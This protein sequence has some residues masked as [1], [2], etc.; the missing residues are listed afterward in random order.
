MSIYTIIYSI[1]VLL[2]FIA[3]AISIFKDDFLTKEQEKKLK[4]WL[5]YAVLEAEKEFGSKTGRI[6]LRY[7]YDKFINL[8]P[9]IAKIISFQR[10]S[11]LVDEALAEFDYLINNNEAISNY[12][13]GGSIQW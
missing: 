3:F 10:F 5:L 9:K 12:V 7:V 11:D 13:K 1:I 8:F 6:K 4:E 2:G